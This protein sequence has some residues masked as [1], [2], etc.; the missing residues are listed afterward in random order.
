MINSLRA[1]FTLCHVWRQWRRKAAKRGNARIGQSVLH[2][3]FCHLI[4]SSSGSKDCSIFISLRA[5]MKLLPVDGW[6]ARDIDLF[7]TVCG[8]HIALWCLS[9]FT[10][11]TCEWRV[12]C[13][14]MTIRHELNIST[15]THHVENYNCNITYL[16]ICWDL[17]HLIKCCKNNTYLT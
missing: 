1:F 9:W 16:Y 7:G 17:E 13:G 11:A 2:L 12:V 3:T 5:W 6:S 15:K 4:K 8:S 14:C 10:D